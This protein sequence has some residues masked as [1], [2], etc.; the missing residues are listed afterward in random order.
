MTSP[1][2]IP[3]DTGRTRKQLVFLLILLLAADVAILMD[4]PVFRQILGIACF[5]ILPGLLILACLR[6]SSSS[7]FKQFVLSIGLS[8]SFLMF[9]GLLINYLYPLFGYPK[10]LSL[11][12]LVASYSGIMLLLWMITYRQKIP[13]IVLP[14]SSSLSDLTTKGKL[15]SPLLFAMLLPLISFL[16]V[17]LLNTQ[18]NNIMLVSLVFIIPIFAALMFMLHDRLPSNAYALTVLMISLALV[19]INP[20]RGEYPVVGGDSG[21]ELNVIR[22]TIESARWS[23]GN[24][25][26]PVNA[27]LSAAILS[28][29]AQMLL[30]ISKESIYRFLGP[31]MMAFVPLGLFI[32]N[33]RYI[34]DTGAFLT[35]LFVACQYSFIINIGTRVQI[36]WFF[37]AMAIVV[38]IDE[39]MQSLIK[40][41]L[42]IVFLFSIIVSYYT[43]S[44]L[45]TITMLL[46]CSFSY[47]Y[48]SWSR[49]SLLKKDI[50]S[51]TLMLSSVAIFFWWSQA[52]EAHFDTAVGFFRN[53]IHSLVDLAVVEAREELGQK[54]LGRGLENWGDMLN[55][56]IFYITA[57]LIAI[58][59][60]VLVFKIIIKK[61]QA[62]FPYPYILL[63]GACLIIWIIAIAAPYVSEGFG[64]DRVYYYGIPLLAPALIIGA[65]ALSKIP[66]SRK[67]SSPNTKSL[68]QWL[69][70]GIILLVITGHLMISM[71]LTWQVFGIHRSVLI[72]NEG[73]QYD[74]WY[75]HLQEV[76]VG[77]WL[78]KNGE[79]DQMIYGDAYLH[80]RFTPLQGKEGKLKVFNRFFK[81]NVHRDKGYIFLRY[82]NV[83]EG[84]ITPWY[85]RK[86]EEDYTPLT[87]YSH[88]FAGK[89]KIYNNG[90]SEV[91]K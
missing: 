79:R 86:V 48:S 85:V 52:T 13:V 42:F 49:P 28:P 82:Q 68:R 69:S 76:A 1:S 71:G 61:R 19:L 25:H 80:S 33:R 15:F 66:L 59:V 53:T 40:R 26:N 38:L 64:I 74:I 8:A 62:I 3:V 72:N 18:S 44:Y 90:G 37:L 10:P 27:C 91:W 30:G 32:L 75:T 45:F 51:G 6:F 21:S 84:K 24:Y 81:D 73:L 20:L 35:S 11:V 17:Y 4:I 22:S 63:M 65:E 70:M 43:Y 12:S 34:R 9:V 7:M 89:S 57:A 2:Q 50:T 46:A 36:A 14:N 23:M 88:L 78:F 67:W 5:F 16:G 47:L 55:A 31:M 54:A 87:K 41:I 56:A 60:S 58:G 83:V 77:N 39:E 29:V